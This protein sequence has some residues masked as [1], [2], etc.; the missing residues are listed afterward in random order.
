MLRLQIKITEKIKL[1]FDSKSYHV[2][3]VDTLVVG[4]LAYLIDGDDDDCSI[5]QIGING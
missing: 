4:F 3:T 2:N 5:P 1:R